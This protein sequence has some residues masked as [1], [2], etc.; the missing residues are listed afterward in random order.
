MLHTSEDIAF[1]AEI[2][3]AVRNYKPTKSNETGFV[4]DGWYADAACTVPYVWTTMPN[5]GITVYAKWVQI[6]YRVFLHPN[7]EDASTNPD[8][9]WGSDTQQ[10]NFRISYGKK[11]ST[12]KGTWTNGKMQ[13][14]AWYLD[15]ACE[16]DVFD[17]DLFVLNDETVTTDYDKTAEE[18]WTDGKDGSNMT[19]YGTINGEGY[20]SD[21]YSRD[22]STG[23]LTERD[24]Y[25]ITKKLDVY[26]L[27]RVVLVGSD[28]INVV[29]DAV[30]YDLEDP[31]TTVAGTV[32][33]AGEG[34]TTQNVATYEDPLLYL[35]KAKAV[36]GPAAVADKVSVE[37]PET[38]TTTEKD[39][40]QFL[41]WDVLEFDVEN[42]EW[43]HMTDDDGKI[44][45]VYPADSFSVFAEK[46][47]I[48]EKNGDGT[49]VEP[50]VDLD[51]VV[52]GKS[53]RYEIK[54]Q[55][56]YGKRE[57]A[58]DTY[59]DWYRNFP[60]D[61]TQEDG[62]LNVDTG[63]QI[64]EP[65]DIY[66]LAEG[67]DIP[68]RPG[69]TF[70]GWARVW[71][72]PLNEDGVPDFD[73]DGVPIGDPIPY[74]TKDDGETELDE[75]DLY[76]RWVEAVEAD[77]E[78]GTEAVPAHYE[79]NKGTAAAPNWVKVTQVAA[80]EKQPYQA[81]YAVWGANFYVFHS[82]DGT[83][84]KIAMATLP[85]SGEYDITEFVK[86]DYLDG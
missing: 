13:F 4:F 76:I 27:W 2:P 64:N 39:L 19:K 58:T 69:Y 35:D 10:M 86:E 29:Y 20:N 53:Y 48:N 56:V 17:G 61:K 79:A 72:Y 62:L 25:W 54:L 55:A 1:E 81:F 80:D 77:E 16:T 63:L 60:E 9:F 30:G 84:D 6:Q 21:L 75:D 38:G 45:T 12:P 23:A 46:C 7:A 49:L 50:S 40:Y 5:G 70:L 68:S 24:R 32:E 18:N 67:S 44:V 26:A 66:T 36:A 65:V 15:E 47:K 14:V 31:D 8:L 57:I 83:V 42:Q 22:S 85:E 41:C 52:D 74:H 73:E 34:D 37:D 3:E 33:I 82:S 28:G 59:I 71:E 11:V 78:A 43:V 51:H